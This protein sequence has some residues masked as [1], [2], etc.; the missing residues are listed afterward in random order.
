MSIHQQCAPAVRL[1][2]AAIAR[3]VRRQVYAWLGDLAGCSD[4]QSA[5]ACDAAACHTAPCS[6]AAQP[7]WRCGMLRASTREGS[8]MGPLAARPRGHRVQQVRQSRLRAPLHDVRRQVHHRHNLAE[9]PGMCAECAT[10]LAC[11]LHIHWLLSMHVE[12]VAVGVC[13]CVLQWPAVRLCRAH[14]FSASATQ[15]HALM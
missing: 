4:A 12:G 11:G 9:C 5:V 15:V 10:P 8:V 1:L 2:V 6:S 7:A 13:D 3:G 14:N